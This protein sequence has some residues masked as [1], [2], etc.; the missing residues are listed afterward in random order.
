MS[1]VLLEH[2][3]ELLKTYSTNIDNFRLELVVVWKYVRDLQGQIN[4]L[5]ED[6]G[7]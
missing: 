5:K 1:D 7:K 3:R 6:F 2:Y 4:K